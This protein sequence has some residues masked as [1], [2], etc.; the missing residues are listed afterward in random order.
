MNTTIYHERSNI[1][2]LAWVLVFCAISCSSR[3]DNENTGGAHDAVLTVKVS[4]IIDTQN[5]PTVIASTSKNDKVISVQSSFEKEVMAYGKDFDALLSTEIPQES[6]KKNDRIASINVKNITPI[7]ATSPIATN[8]NFR[9]LLYDESGINLLKNVV[10]KAG[11]NPNISIDA[12]VKYKWVALS[13]NDTSVPDVSNGQLK[14]G[15]ISNQDLLYAAGNL[16]AKGGQNNLDIVFQRKTTRFDVDIDTRGIFGPINTFTSLQLGTGSGSGYKTLL[17]TAD[18][19]VLTGNFGAIQAMA[20][21]NTA[22]HLM[23]KNPSTTGNLV[24]TVTLYS[25]IP[26]GTNVDPNNLTIQPQFILTLDQAISYPPIGPAYA[27]RNYGNSNTYFT[28]KNP[29]FSIAQGNQYRLSSRMIET[30]VVVGGTSWARSDL[31]YDSRSESIDKYRF[32][33][34]A[35]ITPMTSEY[36]NWMATTPSGTP[37]SG[38]PCLLVYPAGTWRMPTGNELIALS[39]RS[40]YIFAGYSS[41]NPPPEDTYYNRIFINQAWN[42]DTSIATAGNYSVYSDKV[43]FGFNGYRQQNNTI[44]QSRNI[45]NPSIASSSQ[46]V[47]MNYWSGTANGTTATAI[48]QSSNVTIYSNGSHSSSYQNRSSVNTNQNLGLSVRCVRS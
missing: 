40:S 11:T 18:F 22:V 30:P 36:W 37:G 2:F 21:N 42:P 13:I 16:D 32:K 19:D 29:A 4:G 3:D 47:S 46:T 10:A 27:V 23:D 28:F 39:N 9:I 33:A 34:D 26:S 44:V 41:G 7:A 24:K 15:D 5:S 12:D 17:N 43:L 38:D 48:T 6:P 20:N 25:I 14:A 8:I 45:L 1:S 35:A 31:W